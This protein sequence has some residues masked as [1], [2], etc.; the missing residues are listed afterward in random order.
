MKYD[1][2]VIGGGPAGYTAAIVAGMSGARVVLFE[3]EHLG[4]ICLNYGCVPTKA[5]LKSAVTYRHIRKADIIG[6]KSENV[7]FDASV[8]IE[9]AKNVIAKL[10]KGIEYLLNKAGVTIVKDKAEITSPHYVKAADKSFECE[11]IIIATGARPRKI[12]NVLIDGDKIM[13]YKDALFF[14]T[15]PKDMAVIG[16]GAIGMEFA[17][18]YSSFGSR[19]TMIEKEERIL[20]AEDKDVSDLMKRI[21]TKR[22]YRIIT[23]ARITSFVVKDGKVVVSL[24]DGQDIVC[25]K[26][27]VAA[28]VV[29]NIEGIGLEKIGVATAN[30]HILTDQDFATNIDG[31]YAVGDVADHP[32]Y[33]AHKAMHDAKNCVKML[34]GKKYLPVDSVFVPSCIYTSPQIASFGT[35]SYRAGKRFLMANA[36]ALCDGET[37]GFIKTYIDNEDNITGASMIGEGVAEII[38][39]YLAMAA[40]DPAEIIM[41]HPSLAESITASIED[42]VPF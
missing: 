8:V 2:A 31:V 39:C 24:H 3:K 30:G 12:P 19:I 27:L 29:G 23:G 33:L 14:K 7:G 42:V 40:K 13:N 11:N 34:S 10:N 32:P 16:S 21:L 5:I 15:L 22:G 37:D 25:D 38:G 17:E 26:V 4:G 9:R 28:G 35:K 18:I 1:I 36:K 6:I 41:P 20:P